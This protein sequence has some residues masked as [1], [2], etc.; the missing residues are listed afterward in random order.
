MSSDAERDKRLE[1]FTN[2]YDDDLDKV[3]AQQDNELKQRL[4]QEFNSHMGQAEECA[5]NG[6]FPRAYQ[7]WLYAKSV[8]DVLKEWE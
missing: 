8:R 2:S 1:N 3:I 4:V 5:K 6:D 7:Y